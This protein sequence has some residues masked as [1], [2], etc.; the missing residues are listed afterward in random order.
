M[1]VIIWWTPFT[2]LEQNKRKCKSG[3]CHFTEDR[4]YVSLENGTKLILFYG[5]DFKVEDLPLP[6]K[7]E[8]WWG[9]IH[10][11]APHNQPLFNHQPVLELFNLTST[12]KENSGMPLTLLYLQ[13]I[14]TLISSTYFKSTKSKNALTEER[15]ISPIL[16]L[17]SNCDPP[18]QRDKYVEEISKLIPIDSYG[19]C[20]NNRELPKHLR[21]IDSVNHP[22]I[23]KLI[24]NYKFT[25]AFE[26]YACEDYITE[27]LWR[28]LGVGSVP[29]YWGSP[30][31]ENWIPNKNSIIHV[32][33]YESPQHLAIHLLNVLGNDTLY[34]QYLEHKL[35]K[36]VGNK[37]L[38]DALE[39][40]EWG[41]YEDQQTMDTF[42]E[43]FECYVCEM[44]LKLYNVSKPGTVMA[45][46]TH[47]GC[48]APETMLP[49]SD[50]YF[51]KE[52]SMA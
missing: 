5:S 46:K 29:I 32:R 20:L 33:D 16:Y 44:V 2:G 34:E 22:D 31:I 28:P 49:I 35:L 37:K 8:H 10:E 14:D 19:S 40:R 25:I 27:K 4:S 18:S 43:A 12:F 30:S 41:I 24:A 15:T 7:A 52:G 51:W 26:N 36:N 6:R 1:P 23:L 3:S 13:N 50:H 45:D 48:S 9:V 42:V 47:Y 17:Q 39:L 38:K 11:E 21:S